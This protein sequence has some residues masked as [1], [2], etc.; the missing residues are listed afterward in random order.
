MSREITILLVTAGTDFI[1][2]SGTSITAAM[3]AKGDAML[4]TWPVLLVSLIGGL[5]AFARTIQQA[6]KN[7]ASETTTL[8]TTV[9]KE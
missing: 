3:M 8:T 5:V 4:P 1:I 6:L 9:T 2:L 7:Q